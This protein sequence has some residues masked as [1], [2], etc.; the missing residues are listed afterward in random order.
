M[1]EF[2]DVLRRVGIRVCIPA[3][4]VVRMSWGRM[5]LVLRWCG[6]DAEKLGFVGFTRRGRGQQVDEIRFESH[7][8]TQNF[9]NLIKKVSNLPQPL[10]VTQAGTTCDP[11]SLRLRKL[12]DWHRQSVCPNTVR[13]KSVRALCVDST[14]AF[15]MC[16]HARSC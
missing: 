7:Y 12:A 9:L 13:T 14:K 8:K 3:G 10:D 5:A 4:K 16:I 1:K 2:E 6:G 11:A 15:M